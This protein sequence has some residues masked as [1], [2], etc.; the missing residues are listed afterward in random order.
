MKQNTSEVTETALPEDEGSS[1][2][3][4]LFPLSISGMCEKLLEGMKTPLDEC[5]EEE[6]RPA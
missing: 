4:T 1:V 6:Y 2:Q 5:V 3:E